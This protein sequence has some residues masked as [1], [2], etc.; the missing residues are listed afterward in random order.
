MKRN[1]ILSRHVNMIGFRVWGQKVTF[2]LDGT[3]GNTALSSGIFK[4]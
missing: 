3:E 4:S 1:N 2:D